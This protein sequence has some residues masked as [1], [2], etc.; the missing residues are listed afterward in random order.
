MA[1]GDKPTGEA[2]AAPAD[3]SEIVRAELV[4]PA[5]KARSV[6][7]TAPGRVDKP[8]GVP[9]RFGLGTMLVVTAAYGVLLAALQQFAWDR[10]AIAWT[11][12]FI[13][14][15]GAAQMLLFGSQ[16]PRLASLV[17]GLVA[18]PAIVVG[19]SVMHVNR[20]R[21][22]DSG[23]AL[24]SALIFGAPAGYLAG[25]VVAGVFLIMDAVQRALTRLGSTKKVSVT[26]SESF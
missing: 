20:I 5:E 6:A 8:F 10:R 17:T 15:V 9:S 21:P 23:C 7:T 26:E 3:E 19:I 2:P 24:V 16:R 25:G 4:D 14:L 22:S 18:L 12:L 11:V 1:T 13:S